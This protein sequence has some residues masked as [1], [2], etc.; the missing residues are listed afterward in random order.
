MKAPVH[1]VGKQPTKLKLGK[2]TQTRCGLIGVASVHEAPYYELLSE[3]GGDF[4]AT[5]RG[6]L[7]T[8]QKCRNLIDR[9]MIHAKRKKP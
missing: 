3:S 7:A 6:D 1:M 4:K 5:T 8:C 9:G 2:Q